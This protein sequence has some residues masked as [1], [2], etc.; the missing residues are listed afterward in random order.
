MGVILK[1]QLDFPEVGLKV[2]NDVISG[3]FIIDANITA[4]MKRN[5]GGGS[6]DIELIDLPLEKSEAIKTRAANLASVI[7]R[8]G[9]FDSPFEKVMEGIIEKYT[10]AVREG[11]LITSIKGLETATYALKNNVIDHTLEDNVSI[12][13]AVSGVLRDIEIRCG[14]V[15]QNPLLQ[16]L[17]NNIPRKTFRRKKAID[18]LNELARELESEFMISDKKVWLG[19]PIKDNLSYVPPPRFDRAVNLVEFT[20]V[21]KELP[22]QGCRHATRGEGF[23]FTVLGDPKLRPG[24]RVDAAD[25]GEGEFRIHSVTHKFN[26][27]G[28]YVCEG[29]AMKVVSDENF[30]ERERSFGNPGAAGVADSVS[31]LTENGQR[32]RP[33]FEVGKVKT[34]TPGESSDAEKHVSSLYFGQDFERT[35]NQPSVNVDVDANE[36]R[37]FRNKPMVSPFAW[38]KCGLIVPV[39]EGMKAALSHSLNLQDD[40]LVSGFIWSQT[41]DIA[42]PPNKAGDW[43]LCLPIDFDTSSPPSD[44]TKAVNDLTAN[45]GKRLIQLKGLKIM[46]G[47]ST[48]PNVGERPEEGADDEF[49][50]EHKSGTILKIADD[51]KVTIEASNLEITGDLKLT[52]DLTME[53]DVTLTGNITETGDLNVTGNVAIS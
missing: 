52:G 50:I 26:M 37:L 42:P 16:E 48:L 34:Y 43:W 9:Y 32:N 40:V 49:L 35:E 41:P 21:D 28:G 27:S 2:S 8:L 7:I 13:A 25:S 44:S 22:V 3:E 36:Q 29:S 39:Y 18:I 33:T 31:Q 19:K 24:Q 1:Y 15:D 4:E 17:S 11:K 46:I 47:A 30:Y 51:G 20:V 5:V 12:S 45:N 23:R 10:T 14:S 53:G 6:F 38:N